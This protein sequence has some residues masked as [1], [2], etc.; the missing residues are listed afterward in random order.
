MANGNDSDSSEPDERRGAA[1]LDLLNEIMSKLTRYA[2][3]S[4]DNELYNSSTDFL[5]SCVNNR[6][7]DWTPPRTLSDRACVAA[8]VGFSPTQQTFGHPVLEL[9]E[10]RLQSQ[11]KN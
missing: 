11:L 2:R 5:S 6:I 10:L 7:L 4:Y 8:V 3:S 1:P 9:V